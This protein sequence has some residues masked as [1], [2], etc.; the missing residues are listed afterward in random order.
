MEPADYRYLEDLTP[1]EQGFWLSYQVENGL[2]V[3]RPLPQDIKNG[4][5]WFHNTLNERLANILVHGVLPASKSS[6]IKLLTTNY[7]NGISFY[8]LPQAAIARGKPVLVALRP[9]RLVRPVDVIPVTDPKK[10]RTWYSECGDEPKAIEG[11]N[12]F[13]YCDHP[14]ANLFGA[15]EGLLTARSAPAEFVLLSGR[16]EVAAQLATEINEHIKKLKA[17]KEA[18]RVQPQAKAAAPP[19]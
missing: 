13:Y 18:L 12:M 9:L 10:F 3:S 14:E 15:E 8:H 2:L 4:N 1:N 11:S 7:T 6:D 17:P 5:W 19:R 16:P